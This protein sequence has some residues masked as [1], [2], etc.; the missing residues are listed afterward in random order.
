MDKAKLGMGVVFTIF[1]SMFTFIMS[2]DAISKIQMATGF[3]ELIKGIFLLLAVNAFTI[4]G[5]IFLISAISGWIDSIELAK[6]GVVLQCKITDII[7]NENMDSPKYFVCEYQKGNEKYEFKSD[8]LIGDYKIEKDGIVDVLVDPDDYTNYSIDL[9][10]ETNQVYIHR[11][12]CHL[13][14]N[15]SIISII[16]A[17]VNGLLLGIP[18]VFITIPLLKL[19]YSILFVNYEKYSIIAAIVIL[20]LIGVWWLVVYLAAGLPLKMHKKV[21]RIVKNGV[22]VPCRINRKEIYSAYAGSDEGY[23][24]Y[25]YFTFKAINQ[26]DFLKM[27]D[28]TELLFIDRGHEARSK[29]YSPFNVGDLVNVYVVPDNPFE[30]VVEYLN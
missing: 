17:V 27:Q 4:I 20:T 26:F 29:I 15:V 8:D 11:L 3:V 14:D 12:V 6:V 30:Y 28:N 13:F 7:Y 23:R 24:D 19:I 2:P 18:G 5:I 25:L 10:S 16:S 9:S 1:G 21:R 22:C